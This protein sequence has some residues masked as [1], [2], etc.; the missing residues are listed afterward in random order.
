MKR[1]EYYVG[2]LPEDKDT[3]MCAISSLNESENTN[4][5]VEI[6][7]EFDDPN[8]Y[9][10]YTIKGTWDSYRTFLNDETHNPKFVKSLEHFEEC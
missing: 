2:I 1:I 8:G 5:H 9:Y 3:M 4:M 7:G 10:S 6:V